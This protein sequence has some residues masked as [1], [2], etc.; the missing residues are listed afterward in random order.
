MPSA[1]ALL[2]LAVASPTSA[3]DAAPRGGADSTTV[4]LHLRLAG[5]EP[6]TIDV[7]GAPLSAA[8]NAE[9]DRAA[10]LLATGSTRGGCARRLEIWNLETQSAAAARDFGPLLD[11]GAAAL[12]QFIGD[13][14]YLVVGVRGGVEIVEAAELTSL[15]TLYHAGVARA[16][17][18]ADGTLAA[19]QGDDGLV[20]IWDVE[21]LS[22][23]ARIESS[24]GTAALALSPDD[25]W[26]ATL[27]PPDV[28]RLWAVAP[29]ELIQQACRWLAEP[30]P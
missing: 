18:Q 14:N 15:A 13:D 12:L 3:Q 5:V 17:I 19:T 25:R 1:L 7:E 11:Q 9:G 24:P 20:R 28:V 10:V 23:I 27:E 8:L 30:C 26:L 22:E 2:L 4:A 29:D 21:T 16:A 6:R